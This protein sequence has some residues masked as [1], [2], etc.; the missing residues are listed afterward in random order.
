MLNPRSSSHTG[1][2]QCG[3]PSTP[4]CLNPLYSSSIS[5][6]HMFICW[7]VSIFY[8]SLLSMSSFDQASNLG[9]RDMGFIHVC[10]R[11]NFLPVSEI[12][13]K[14]FDSRNRLSGTGLT[15][16]RLPAE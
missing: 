6:L 12:S 8:S 10:G 15:I 5:L 9:G 3:H 1:Y 11:N 7:L 14:S 13:V 2:V 4:V 16:N